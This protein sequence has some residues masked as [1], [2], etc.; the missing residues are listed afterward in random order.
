MKFGLATIILMRLSIECSVLYEQN[1]I[2]CL[3]T[4]KYM[5]TYV[6]LGELY[7]W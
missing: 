1:G 7:V 2:E 3:F 4:T 6:W 5:W